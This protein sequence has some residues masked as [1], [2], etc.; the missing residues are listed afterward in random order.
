MKTLF[1][2]GAIYSPVPDATAMLI[3]DHSIVWIGDEA[4]AQVYLDTDTEVVDLAGAFVA[5]P[6]IDG[7]YLGGASEGCSNLIV[8]DLE[9]SNPISSASPILLYQELSDYALSELLAAHNS[10]QQSISICLDPVLAT[11]ARVLA[12]NGIPFCFGSWGR[13]SSP[14]E[15]LDLATGSSANPGLSERAAFIAA[16]RGAM[17]V[18]PNINWETRG[19]LDAGERANFAIWHGEGVQVRAADERIAAWSTDPRSGVPG[20]PE[21]HDPASR[22]ILRTL[23][24]DGSPAQSPKHTLVAN[25]SG[26][27]R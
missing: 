25:Q 27:S 5:P 17:R 21:F 24:L 12:K 18:F 19:V 20:L 23:Y 4:A 13:Y 9:T 10:G 14:W 11:T 1:S 26:T 8:N 16:T 2:G 7:A 3:E 15:W 6:F 22:P